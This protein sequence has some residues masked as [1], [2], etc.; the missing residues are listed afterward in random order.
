MQEKEET[1]PKRHRRQSK[2]GTFRLN[3]EPIEAK[4]YKTASHKSDDKGTINHLY[5]RKNKKQILNLTHL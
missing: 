2:L 1:R 5:E 3:K 4:I